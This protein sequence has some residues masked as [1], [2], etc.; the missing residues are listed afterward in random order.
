MR[1][2]KLRMGRRRE[3]H[4]VPAG[5]SAVIV[6]IL[7]H[8]PSLSASYD[9]LLAFSPSG[10]RLF[11]T[12]ARAAVRF[13]SS[14]SRRTT[15]RRAAMTETLMMAGPRRGKRILKVV[16]GKRPASSCCGKG[17]PTLISDA[18]RRSHWTRCMRVWNLKASSGVFANSAPLS[19]WGTFLG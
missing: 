18:V 7:C 11:G 12:D 5:R 13:P 10:L 16:A 19:M 14:A 8:L 3:L 1:N 17:P 2:P 6:A 9:T 4:A 15:V